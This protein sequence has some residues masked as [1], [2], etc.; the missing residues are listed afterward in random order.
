MY[1]SSYA[2]T[3]IMFARRSLL[4]PSLCVGYSVVASYAVFD[5]MLKRKGNDFCF[6]NSKR[7]VLENIYIYV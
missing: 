7:A 4:I 1:T 5:K 3:T 2:C 6:F